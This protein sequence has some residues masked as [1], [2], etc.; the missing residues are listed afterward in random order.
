M[1]PFN[2]TNMNRYTASGCKIQIWRIGASNK[3]PCGLGYMRAEGRV[4]STANH[5]IKAQWHFYEARL[6]I[7]K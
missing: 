1:T 2:S 3:D 7:N 5:A 4:S 6:T